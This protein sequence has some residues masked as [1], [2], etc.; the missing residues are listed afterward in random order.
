MAYLK[1]SK[2]QKIEIMV[3]SENESVEMN[4]ST[5]PIETGS[6]ITD[7]VQ[8]NNKIFSFTGLIMGRDQSEVDNRYIQLLWWSQEGEELQYHGAI[9]HDNVI[10]S[11]LSKTYDEGG[12]ANAVKFEIELTALYKVNLNWVKNKNYGKKQATPNDGVW[13]TVV[14]GNT[15]WG[16][17]QQ[18]GTSIDQL[19]SWNH[20]PDRQIP[21]GVRARVK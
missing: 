4:V 6:P 7:H 16:W 19:R 8:A 10:I 13:V 1:N 12:F 14:P 5:H 17:W 18:Y 3:E 15:Y 2:G 9:R 21:V 11:H 20:W